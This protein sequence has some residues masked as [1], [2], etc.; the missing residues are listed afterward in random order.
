MESK[1]FFSVILTTYNRKELVQRALRSLVNQTE[2]DWEAIVIDDGSTDKTADAVRAGFQN[3]RI[4]YVYKENTGFILAKN[5]GIELAKGRYITF[6]DSDDE[7]APEHLR[8]RKNILLKN[9][10]IDLLHG[11]VEIIGQP[12]VPDVFNPHVKIHLSDCAVSGTFFIKEKAMHQLK[13][14]GGTALTTDFDFMQRAEQA[15]LKIKKTDYPTYIYHRDEG[16]SITN[17]ML[18]AMD[19]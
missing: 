12:Y 7:Y 2:K 1:V 4:Q 16:G 11:G 5:R 18:R 10:E 19:D 15:G 9:P 13:G 6:L 8:I 17:D 3:D 14:F